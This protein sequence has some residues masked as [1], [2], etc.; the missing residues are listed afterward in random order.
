SLETIKWY[1]S[2]FKLS[3]IHCLGKNYEEL[4]QLFIIGD[5]DLLNMIKDILTL[6]KD[7]IICMI[8]NSPEYVIKSIDAVKLFK[9]I[10][11][12]F[13]ITNNILI[14]NNYCIF[15]S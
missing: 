5:I 10:D 9:W 15:R 14:Q 3:A 11:E 2:Y 4:L 7:R 8:E 1:V 12:H 13:G 6:E